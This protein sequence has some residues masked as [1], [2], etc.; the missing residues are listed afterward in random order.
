MK[1]GVIMYIIYNNKI[2]YGKADNKIDVI[3]MVQQIFDAIDTESD[4]VTSISVLDTERFEVV[5][6]MRVQHF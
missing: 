4:E 3:R 6:D 1:G 5:I 2:E